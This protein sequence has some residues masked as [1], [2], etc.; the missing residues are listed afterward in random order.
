MSLFARIFIVVALLVGSAEA[1][2][3]QLQS[4]DHHVI[5]PVAPTMSGTIREGL[6]HEV[7]WIEISADESAYA[8][9][10]IDGLAE[11]RRD[12]LRYFSFYLSTGFA[13]EYSDIVIYQ[14]TY[15]GFDDLVEVYPNVVLTELGRVTGEEIAAYF[16]S[17][18]CK[19]PNAF[20]IHG[21]RYMPVNIPLVDLP[22]SD[23]VEAEGMNKRVFVI[24]VDGG[25]DFYG[26]TTFYGDNNLIN[27]GLSMR[28][29]PLRRPAKPGEQ[30]CQG[31]AANIVGT[32]N[33][34]ILRG[35]D[36]GDVIVVMGDN[37]II[38]GM[39][40]DDIICIKEGNAITHAGPGNDE[41]YVTSNK[42]QL[43]FGGPGNDYLQDG[44]GSS[45]LTGGP[46]NDI[47]IGNKGQDICKG[48]SGKDKIYKSCEIRK[49]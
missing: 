5:K 39:E 27:S 35:T 12:L 41:V 23:W 4:Y 7:P 38:Y 33:D 13:A 2:W 26:I 45:N 21:C 42:S 32:K 40:G 29:M 25:P 24:E 47:L 28:T 44:S 16:K 22:G 31:Y 48:N 11:D 10:P 19:D 49:H 20:G 30:S 36:Q 18:D 17:L 8:V 46:G 15:Y 1:Q 9:F 34:E 14:G 37:N 6:L 43:I 3:G